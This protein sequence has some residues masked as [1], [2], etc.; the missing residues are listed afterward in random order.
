MSVFE[1]PK[2]KISDFHIETKPRRQIF[3]FVVEMW[4]VWQTNN[5]LRIDDKS[6]A[7]INMPF[8]SIHSFILSI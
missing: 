8:I 4:N 3:Q 5:G 1:K 6:F 7:N 2:S